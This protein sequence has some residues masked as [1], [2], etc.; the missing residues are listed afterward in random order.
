MPARPPPSGTVTS[1]ISTRPPAKTSSF[2]AEGKRSRRNI[3]EAAEYSGLT[4]MLR[5]RSS[6]RYSICPTYW[7]SRTR[8]MVCW[9]PSFLASRQAS[10]FC[11]SEAVVAIIRSALPTW[12]SCMT[13]KVAQLPT[14]PMTSYCPFISS[15]LAALTSTTVTL[16]PS[17]LSCC[18]TSPPTLPPPATTI[19]MILPPFGSNRSPAYST[20]TET[21]TQSRYS[22][23]S[24]SSSQTSIS[25]SPALTAVRISS[26]LRP[27][28][29][30]APHWMSSTGSP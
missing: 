30:Q 24:H 28:S 10:R 3:S 16:W 9:A 5:P 6:E 23:V 15:T 1:T 8:A 13:C 12:A 11:S 26:R 29:D 20:E 2:W 17:W 7:G 27:S 18:T 25:A 21:E 4:Y 14:M 19:F 22:M